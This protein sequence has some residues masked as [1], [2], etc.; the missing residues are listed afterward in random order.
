LLMWPRSPQG[1]R[2]WWPSRIHRL[3]LL[4]V[5]INV[6]AIPSQIRRSELF[7]INMNATAIS[8]V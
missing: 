1:G 5:V 4:I 8:P 6:A 3:E 2:I 7:I